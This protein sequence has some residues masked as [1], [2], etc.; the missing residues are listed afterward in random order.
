MGGAYSWC[1]CD[2]VQNGVVLGEVLQLI[3]LLVSVLL[4]WLVLMLWL[5]VKLV[6]GIVVGT[7]TDV[8]SYSSCGGGVLPVLGS[9]PRPAAHVR[10]HHQ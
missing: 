4:M 10:H 7:D 8:V 9:L 1:L 5:S 6:G 3:I 2:G